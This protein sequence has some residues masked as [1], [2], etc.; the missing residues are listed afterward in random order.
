MFW[1]SSLFWLVLNKATIGYRRTSSFPFKKK[2]IHSSSCSSNSSTPR[3]KPKRNHSTMIRIGTW[4]VLLPTDEYDADYGCPLQIALCQNDATAK[5]ACTRARQRRVWNAIE[6]SSAALDVLSLQE[7]SD[8]FL[9]LQSARRSSRWT[10]VH[11]SD[12][13]ALLL[14]T[15]SNYQAISVYNVHVERL[16]GCPSVPVVV[17]GPRPTITNAS[18][19]PDSGARI[20]VGSVHVQPSSS[21]ASDTM[22]AWYAAAAAA[23][24][25]AT[26]AW[27]LRYPHRANS[28]IESLASSSSATVK[29][30]R[31]VVAPAVAM[32]LAGDFNYNLTDPALHLPIGWNLVHGADD[33]DSGIR[34]T[35]QKEDNWMGNFDGFFV[36]SSPL[37]PRGTKVACVDADCQLKATAVAVSMRGF[38]PK[39]VRGF[40]QGGRIHATAQFAVAGA[41]TTAN[42]G[43]A[44]TVTMMNLLT[45]DDLIHAGNDDDLRLLFSKSSNFNDN[46]SDVQLVPL[47]NPRTQSLS[48]HVLVTASFSIATINMRPK[49]TTTRLVPFY[50]TAAVI[51]AVLAIAA[52]VRSFGNRRQGFD[53]VATRSSVT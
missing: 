40:T 6:D 27:Q 43:D 46:R 1:L 52:I 15:R 33:D 25:N 29:P 10:L 26:A 36:A 53:P 13:C 18:T 35:S 51:A 38:M 4:N 7:V 37:P 11:R 30:T 49:S 31:V 23:M 47:S 14:S 8:D 3:D 42:D 48:D 44:T 34:G 12:E 17:F 45:P 50:V 20:A 2:N 16:S 28:S 32:V 41:T 21:S 5:A 19:L 39:V 24:R 9:A 22:S